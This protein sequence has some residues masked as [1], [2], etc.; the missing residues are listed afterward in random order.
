MQ[1]I[2]ISISHTK[3]SSS[4]IPTILS[5]SPSLPFLIKNISQIY[6]F[7]PSLNLLIYWILVLNFS[8]I[9]SWRWIGAR[10]CQRFGTKLSPHQRGTQHLLRM[11][12]LEDLL[13]HHSWGRV[14]DIKQVSRLIIVNRAKRRKWWKKKRP[15]ALQ[16]EILDPESRVSLLQESSLV[17]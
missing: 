15:S 16:L 13:N 1:I 12:Q 5:L 10:F 11:R 3:A 14:G 7:L 2:D 9:C 8:H 6:L 4:R 17:T